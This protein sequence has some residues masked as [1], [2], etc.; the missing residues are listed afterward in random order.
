MRELRTLISDGL[1]ESKLC[2][3]Q[4]AGERVPMRREEESRTGTSVRSK[5]RFIR[6][7]LSKKVEKIGS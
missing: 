6:S 3:N 5:I 2:T 7:D 4:N 1:E